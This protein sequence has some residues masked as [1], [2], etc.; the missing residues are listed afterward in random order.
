MKTFSFFF[1]GV[2]VFFAAL[3]WLVHGGHSLWMVRLEWHK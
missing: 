3:L 2:W 1:L